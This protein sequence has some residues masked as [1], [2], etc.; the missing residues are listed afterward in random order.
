MTQIC[1]KI[2]QESDSIKKRSIKDWENIQ[3]MLHT[4]QETD[5]LPISCT[6]KSL[7]NSFSGK[8]ATALQQYHLLNLRTIGQ[9]TFETYIKHTFLGTSSTKLTIHRVNLKTFAELKP[10]K[11]RL[12]TSE[13][14]KKVVI[15]CLKKKMQAVTHGL[16]A[17]DGQ[18]YL[19]LPRSLADSQ[20]LP[21]T[22]NKAGARDYL[23]ERY[24]SNNVVVPKLPQE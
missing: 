16:M 3:S 7:R 23:E 2:P 5:L 20:G 14:D 19:E 4:I 18:Q 11:Q 1:V 21:N 15:Q 13:R 6:E 22:G 9:S 12:K 10:S 17:M 24:T 8:V